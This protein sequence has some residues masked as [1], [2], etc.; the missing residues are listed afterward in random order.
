MNVLIVDDEPLARKR[1][2]QFVSDYPGAKLIA[3]CSSGQL[4]IDAVR[5]HQV[6]VILLDVQMAG[7]DGFAVVRALPTEA[8]P[9][10]IFVT[11]HDAHALRAFEVAAID[12]VTKPVRRE[13]L[14]AA[15]DRARG[16][17]ASRESAAAGER[18]QRMLLALRPEGGSEQ[19]SRTAGTGAER[20]QVRD[21]DN[22]LFLAT[23]DV[24]WLEADGPIVRVHVG[25]SI[26][27]VRD[28]L[29]RF[30]ESLDN[31]RFVRIH[32]SI[33]VNLDVVRHLQ[34]WFGGDAFL[35]LRDGQR[36]KVSRTYRAL[37]RA[38]LNAI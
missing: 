8:P 26:Y 28:T 11:A 15:L 20:L 24:D 6:D 10:V 36:L 1:L 19:P 25:Q 3:E 22:T 7:M 4:A 35:V 18:L 23:R 33:V 38:R 14:H 27:K 30:E 37:L 13:R 29:S 31:A 34:P 16:V 2:R 17:L 9:V 12:F 32:R 5:T 21:G